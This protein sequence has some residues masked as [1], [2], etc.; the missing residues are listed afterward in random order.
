MKIRFQFPIV[1]DE[2]KVIDNKGKRREYEIVEGGNVKEVT[3]S[4]NHKS[5]GK[6][7]AVTSAS[8]ATKSVTVE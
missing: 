1:D 4:L 2:Y 6:K 5:S 8:L 7:K 3:E